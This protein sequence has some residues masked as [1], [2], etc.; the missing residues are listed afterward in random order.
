MT[1]EEFQKFCEQKI[2]E[3]KEEEKRLLEE[4]EQKRKRKRYHGFDRD[5]I[6]EEG[7]HWVVVKNNEIVMHCD[8]KGEAWRELNSY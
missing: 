1:L 6:M 7:G 4:E 8:T 2:K 3:C 5:F